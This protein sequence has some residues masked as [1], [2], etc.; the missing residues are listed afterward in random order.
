MIEDQRKVFGIGMSKTGTSTL[1]ACFRILGLVPVA[2]Y[3]AELKALV[4]AGREL[5]PINDKFDYD[6][7]APLVHEEIVEDILA[8]ARSYVSFQ[9]SPWYML[10]CYLDRVFP[11]SKFILTVRRDAETQAISD[12]YHNQRRGVCEDK[13]DPNF[14]AAQIKRYQ[15]HN[16]AV[17]E[18]FRGRESDLLVVCW[19]DGHGWNELCSFL[20]VP[21]PGVPFPH[22]NPGNYLTTV[23]DEHK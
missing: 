8:V 12:W 21:H 3:N 9:D 17:R 10:Y 5:D 23:H 20:G 13:P 14:L 15:D 22:A 4:R 16:Q 6:V 19:E 7:R 2:G 11:G 1:D 18:Y